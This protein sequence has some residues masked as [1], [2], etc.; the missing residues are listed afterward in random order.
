MTWVDYKKASDMVPH[1]WIVESL[2]M[3]GKGS[4][5]YNN[6]SAEIYGKL[7]DRTDIMWR[8]TWFS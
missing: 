5:K 8:D 6:V 2:K 1:S 3:A 4:G 7:E